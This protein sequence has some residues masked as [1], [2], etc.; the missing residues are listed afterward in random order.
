MQNRIKQAIKNKN[1][2]VGMMNSVPLPMIIEMIG[3][4]GYDFV[5]IDMEHL[6]RDPTE[7]EHAIR[8]AFCVDIVPFVRVPGPL[9]HLIKQS[10]DAG[11]M[12]IVVPQI[13]SKAQAQLVVD[14]CRFPPVGHRGVTGGFNTGFGRLPIDEY[15]KVANEE[16]MITLMIES[17]EGVEN[18]DQ[19]LSVTGIDMILEG[20]LD[21]AVSLG[22]PESVS[23][24]IVQQAISH[25]ANKCAEFEVPFC[26]IPREPEQFGQWCDKGITQFVAGQDRGILFRALKSKLSS[27]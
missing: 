2:V 21:L 27:F 23:H 8:S 9:P 13:S 16:V 1:K 24:P 14:T 10:L 5:I 12:G 6:L 15:V 11:A 17:K 19:I 26:A 25:I 3:Y 7:L 4:A 20:A 22:Y 18:L